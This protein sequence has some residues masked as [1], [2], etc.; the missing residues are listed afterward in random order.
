MVCGMVEFSRISRLKLVR[1]HGGDIIVVQ[2]REEPFGQERG[3]SLNKSY[4][5][6]KS[7]RLGVDDEDLKTRSINRTL[8]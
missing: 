4:L 2:Q 7:P 1:C 3:V 6:G 5:L 8:Q